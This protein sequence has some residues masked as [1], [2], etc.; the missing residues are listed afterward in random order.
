VVFV[1]SPAL[2]RAAHARVV[3]LLAV[4]AGLLGHCGKAASTAQDN[5]GGSAGSAGQPPS[6]GGTGPGG[7]PGAPEASPEPDAVSTPDA[8]SAIDAAPAPTNEAFRFVAWGDTKDQTAILAQLSPAVVAIAP[9]FSIYSG[10]LVPG[11]FTQVDGTTWLNALNANSTNKLSDITFTVRG[12]HDTGPLSYWET[13]FDQQAVA[14]RARAVN[15]TSFE[16]NRSYSF[17]VA[18]AHF[19][20]VDVPGDVN[21]MNAAQLQWIDADLSAAETRGYTHA[22]LYW[23]GPLYQVAEH[24]CTSFPDIIDV[25]NK[26][27]IVTA[28]FHGHEHTYAWVHMDNTRY[29]NLTH[30]FEE[31]IGGDAGAGPQACTSRTPDYCQGTEHGFMGV[32]VSGRDFSV[33]YYVLSGSTPVRTLKF[34]KP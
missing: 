1:H 32:D 23:H 12:N 9:R 25:F 3:A 16:T 30:E 10:D 13:F 28:T 2:E 14:G 7:S 33:N 24:C 5:S 8:P 21:L 22:F 27:P 34:T 31:F 20:A 17:D 19:V 26:H 29:P 18:N 4:A 11:G 6:G 15:Y